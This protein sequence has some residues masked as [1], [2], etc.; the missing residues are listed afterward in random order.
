MQD[1]CSYSEV[2]RDT[3]PKAHK[4]TH[5]PQ[6]AGVKS[7]G[8]MGAHMLSFKDGNSVKEQSVLEIKEGQS[9]F[10]PWK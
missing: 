3:N 4:I 10:T 2:H 9:K 1:T 7:D 6:E 8:M 5:T